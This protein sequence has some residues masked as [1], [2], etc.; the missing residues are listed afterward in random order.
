MDPSMMFWFLPVLFSGIG[1]L[2]LVVGVRGAA[3]NRAFMR[4][5]QR[6]QGQVVELRHR[7]S[8]SSDGGSSS[9]WHPV[10]AFTTADGRRV[11]AESPI[12]S[13]P[14]PTGQGDWVPVL[15]DPANP[16]DVRVDTGMGRGSFVWGLFSVIGA[17]FALIGLA[18]LGG[19]G[20][21]SFVR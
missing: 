5:A 15:Y 2:F 13:S 10:L 7:W 8:S 4:R 19:M 12:G 14:A 21:F 1:I 17:V 11:Q 3:S 18:W 6:V 9:S 20:W 16:G